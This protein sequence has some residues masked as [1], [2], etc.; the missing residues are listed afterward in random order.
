MHALDAYDK[1]FIFPSTDATTLTFQ[2]LETKHGPKRKTNEQMPRIRQ[3][4]RVTTVS[5]K[6]LGRW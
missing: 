6:F 4:I 2:D 3:Q 1:T 5:L